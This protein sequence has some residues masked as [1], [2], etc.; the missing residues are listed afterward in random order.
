[1]KWFKHVERASSE[2]SIKGW[3]GL[4]WL[5]EVK[6]MGNDRSSEL[7]D[8]IVKCV[9]REQWRK[10]VNTT[11]G[12]CSFSNEKAYIRPRKLIF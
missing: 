6:K 7:R 11:S 9:D 10:F 4:R 12:G 1:M 3:T 8:A 2:R 5:D